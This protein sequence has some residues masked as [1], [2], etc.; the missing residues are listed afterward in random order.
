M[1]V[2]IIGDCTQLNYQQLCRLLIDLEKNMHINEYIFS[3]VTKID[4]Y[5]KRYVDQ[6]NHC[7]KIIECSK[8]RDTYIVKEADLVFAILNS[9]T[10]TIP[11]V[12]KAC[13]EGK[14][15]ILL[16]L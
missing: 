16:R 13:E 5:C 2:A 4:N 10:L 12:L 15:L 14:E 1:K 8:N 6:V 7:Y 11:C 3:N 9:N